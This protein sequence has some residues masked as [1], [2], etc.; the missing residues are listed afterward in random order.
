[1]RIL[2]LAQRYRFQLQRRFQY[3]LFKTLQVS[4]Y[5]GTSYSDMEFSFSLKDFFFDLPKAGN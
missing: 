4:Y 5:D 1:M 3:L 2:L